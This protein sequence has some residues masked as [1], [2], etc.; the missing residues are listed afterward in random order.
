VKG[1][2]ERLTRIVLHGAQ[3]PIRVG[4]QQYAP[5]EILAEMPPIAALDDTQIAYIL[6]FI[7]Q[8]WGQDAEPVE[9]S[10]ILEIRQNTQDR[11]QPWTESELLQIP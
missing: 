3:G 2:I 1:S 9:T 6:T 7:R 10:R 5:P 8:A 11:Q 4:G